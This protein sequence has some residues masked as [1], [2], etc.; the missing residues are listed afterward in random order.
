VPAQSER[1]QFAVDSALLSE[2]GEKLVSTVHVA[3]TELVKNAYDADATQVTVRILPEGSLGPRVIVEDNGVGMTLEQVRDF[4][5]KIGTSNKVQAPTTEKFG[6]LKT[7]SK[8]VGRFACRRLGL[9]LRLT[10]TAEVRTTQ[11]RSPQYQTT[12]IAFDWAQFKPGI[13][14]ESVESLGETEISRSGKVGTTLEVWGS[15][16]DEWHVRGFEY[17]Q[18]QLA[19]LVNN[20]GA[21]RPGYQE[22]PGFN[23]LLEAP[24]YSGSPVDLREAIIDATWGTL[25]ASIDADGRAICSLSAKGIGGTKKFVSKQRFLR[26]VG[27]SLRVGILPAMK[28]EARKPELLAKYVLTDLINEWGGIHLRFNGF[29]MFP[30]GDPHDDWLRI[31]ADRGRRLGK[32]DG[33]LFDFASSLDRVDAGRV[34][35]NMLGMRNYIGQVDATSRIKGLTPRIDRQGFIE[36]EVFD[37]IRRFARFSIEWAIIH[38]DNY[39]RKREHEEAEKAREA[40]RPVLNLDGPKEQVVPKAASFLKGEIKRIVRRLPP[41]QQK[42]TERTLVRTVKAIETAS[43]ESYKQLEH[44]RLI[45]SASTLTLLFAHEVRTVIGALGGAS[46]RLEQLAKAV[47]GHAKELNSLGVQLRETKDRFDNLVAMTGIV[48]AFGKTDTLTELHLKM[49]IERAVRC[50]HLVVENY[51]ISVDDANI[52]PGLIVGP[53]VEGELYTILLNLLSNSVKSVIAAGRSNRIIRFEA[54]Q[55][56]KKVFVRVL[57][58]GIGLDKEFFDEVFTPFI[59]DPSGALYDRLE[60]RANPEDASIFGTGSGLGLSIARDVA[61][62]RGG[63]IKFLKPSK[64]WS[65]CVEVELP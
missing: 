16:T 18:R 24:G 39:I 44:L 45:A 27:A 5:M 55:R 53:M 9:H 50:F 25:T 65:A 51:E 57:D 56:G 4:W 38:R 58:N 13:D 17:L 12:R 8:G 42:E 54:E 7:G 21:S 1:F 41:T 37:E 15:R 2:L 33:E 43:A 20:R 19:L 64:P 6:R 22:D 28:D 11:L 34:L 48:G 3:L 59:S 30:Y 36:N 32:P 29:R 60:E 46:L 14:V 47:P 61:Q 23:V 49:A 62:S 35:L 26:I 10:T 31:D 40:I 63:D 52:P